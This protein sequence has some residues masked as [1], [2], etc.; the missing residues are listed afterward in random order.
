MKLITTLFFTFNLLFLSSCSDASQKTVNAN[1]E[2]L[3]ISQN[4]NTD[5]QYNL[6]MDYL[7]GENGKERNDKKAMYWFKKAADLGD[8]SAQNNLAILYAEGKGVSK[9]ENEAERYFEMAAKQ[10][11]PNALVQTARRKLEKIALKR[12]IIKK[13]KL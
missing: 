7:Y 1:E 2:T 13:K 5:Y 10:N 11:H 6:G 4:E 3:N 8:A 12:I 9:N